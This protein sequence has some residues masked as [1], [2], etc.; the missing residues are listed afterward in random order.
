MEQAFFELMAKETGKTL[1]P[2]QQQAVL[3]TEGP[4]L[5]L[6][7]PGSGKTTTLNMKIAYLVLEK[8]V[9]PNAIL[10]LTF[11]K[12]SAK[13]M[14]ERFD[15]FFHNLIPTPVKFSTIHSFAFK[16]VREYFYKNKMAYEL[17][18][19]EVEKDKNQTQAGDVYETA[20]N[21]K[22]ILRRLYR[23]INGA[24]VTEEQMDELLKDLGYV[25]NKMLAL[26]N[27]KQLKSNVKNFADL[28]FAYES[29]KRKDP[30][31]LLLDFDDM[32][33]EAYDI[34]E[35]DSA[36]LTHYQNIYQYILTD[37]SQDTSL[38]QHRIIQKLAEPQNNLC[39][40]A[41]DDQTL[42][43]WRGADVNELM[44]FKQKYP[45]AV[46]LKME[47]NYRSTKDIVDTANAFIKR[48]KVR[49]PKNMF[50]ENESVEPIQMLNLDTYDG[51]LTYVIEQLKKIDNWNETAVLYRN[52]GSSIN[53][54]NA[55]DIAGIPFYIK[56][57][58][59][60]FFSHWVLQDVLNF[61][62]FSKD[63][64]DIEQLEKIHMKFNGY[65]S[66]YQVD[67]LKRVGTKTSI[68]DSL[69]EHAEL[70]SWQK[71]NL[72]KIKKMFREMNTMKP[73]EAI[74]MMRTKL[75]YEKNLKNICER[76]GFNLD[77]LLEILDSLEKVA[78]PLSTL[79][80]FSLR[81]SQLEELLRTSK[82]NK[83]K[84]AVT[85]STFHSSKGLEFENVYMID[86]INGVIP[87]AENISDYNRGMQADME[88][89]VR[90]FYVGMTRAKRHLTLIS[91]NRKGKEKVT[92]SVFV[93][94]VR[95]ILYPNLTE[96]KKPQFVGKSVSTLLVEVDMVVSHKAFGKG[97]ITQVD[98]D[99]VKIA[100]DNG[101]T[102]QLSLQVCKENKLLK[103]V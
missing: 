21:K 56:D 59:N 33:T 73:V 52:N 47:Q 28:Y 14:E 77:G 66:K 98:N 6:A 1:N 63:D 54:I 16:I 99:L 95:K 61:M 41:D 38:V 51:Q 88:E 43:T 32:L 48:N 78:E 13:D 3:H 27:I 76:L 15:T 22:L 94:D 7:S 53:L 9:N 45:N 71:D 62:D 87:S 50:T 58:D 93:S 90:L 75:G 84:N 19:G 65:I 18:E 72:R 100:F 89:A 8:N 25:K 42:Y 64:A 35:K 96:K 82:F 70:K 46:I 30:A 44:T 31:K 10:A 37:E 34:L 74:Q 5:L 24:N 92:E 36:I 11:S 102:K 69:L 4:L 80:E 23:E 79:D 20:L 81:L 86:L 97:K 12:A 68:F 40:V 49:Y 39:V 2:I 85:L 91:Y 57:S 29:F 26:Q 17:I 101:M 103:I 55:L 60:K 83:R 67:L